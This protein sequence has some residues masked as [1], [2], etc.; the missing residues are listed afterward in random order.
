MSPSDIPGEEE[1]PAGPFPP[2][3]PDPSTGP[4]ASPG[5]PGGPGGPP[6]SV[7]PPLPPN[8]PVGPD[9]SPA[10]PGGPGGPAGSPGG[11]TA[12]AP[13]PP[14]EP[15]LQHRATAALFVALLSL[16][17]F[18]GFNVQV[19]RGIL[20]VIYA[21]LAG[22]TALWLALTAMGRARRS[23]TA[24]PRGSVAATA[25]ASVG[26]GLAAAMLVAFGLFGQQLSGY[27]ECLS[28]ANTLAAQQSCYSKFSHAL[29]QEISVLSG[30]GARG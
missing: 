12:R 13:L 29:N 19:H 6:A 9:A 3:P 17:G 2:L 26:I 23:H 27:G 5:G 24:R 10:G 18:L 8:P 28:G 30:L 25:I 22:T 15:A 16:A 7:F 14:P 11:V 1:P 4:S 21:L 20:I